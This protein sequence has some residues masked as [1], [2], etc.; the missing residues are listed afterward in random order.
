MEINAGERIA[1]DRALVPWPA[2]G[3]VSKTQFLHTFLSPISEGENPCG[4]VFQ[5]NC[6]GSR[7]ESVLLFNC[8]WMERRLVQMKYPLTCL[9]GNN[10]LAFVSVPLRPFVGGTALGTGTGFLFEPDFERIFLITNRHLVIE[11]SEQFFP[12]RLILKLHTDALDLKKFEDWTVPL[13]S[14]NGK[15]DRAWLELDPVIDVIALEL[16]AVE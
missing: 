5:R 6:V 4:W 16:N 3:F 11:E 14:E 12:D 9:E 10:N 13:Y 15:G 7:T 2:A 1:E 8:K